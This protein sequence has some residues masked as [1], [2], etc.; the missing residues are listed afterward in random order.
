M[1]NAVAD[2]CSNTI[3]F[4]KTKVYEENKL[5]NFFDGYRILQNSEEFLMTA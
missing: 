2:Y 4:K 3:P 1:Y 5:A